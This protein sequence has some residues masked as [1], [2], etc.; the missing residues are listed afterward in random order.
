MPINNN[1]VSYDE[2]IWTAVGYIPKGK[3]ATYGQIAA[4]AGFPRTAR[5]VGR[6]LS[7]LPEDTQIP[8]FRVIN[9]KGEISFPIDSDRYD[10]QK[11]HL[12]EELI[13]VRNGKVDLKSYRWEI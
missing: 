9:A 10:I 4:I 6:A 7:K 1:T 12:E 2:A 11:Q 8:W 13:I 5:A 3:V